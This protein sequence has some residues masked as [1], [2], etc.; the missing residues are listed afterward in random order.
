MHNHLS[1]E[2]LSSYCVTP[3]ATTSTVCADE[4]SGFPIVMGSPDPACPSPPPHGQQPVLPI[5]TTSLSVATSPSESSQSSPSSPSLPLPRSPVPPAT[6]CP[7]PRPSTPPLSERLSASVSM[8]ASPRHIRA[9]ILDMHIDFGQLHERVSRQVE[10]GLLSCGPFGP[11]NSAVASMGRRRAFSVSSAPTEDDV[12]TVYYDCIPHPDDLTSVCSDEQYHDASCDHTPAFALI[13]PTVLTIRPSQSSPMLRPVKPSLSPASLPST[14]VLETVK[15]PLITPAASSHSSTHSIDAC[16]EPSSPDHDVSGGTDTPRV[17]GAKVDNTLRELWLTEVNYIN[18]LDTFV[19]GYLKTIKHSK[20]LSCLLLKHLIKYLIPLVYFQKSFSRQLGVTI[21]HAEPRVAP[22]SDFDLLDLARLFISMYKEFE[23]YIPYCAMAG[24]FAADIKH[25]EKGPEWLQFSRHDSPDGSGPKLSRLGMLDY[26]MKP[27]Q[28]LC[29]YPLL[30]KSIAKHYST[31]SVVAQQITV[32]LD[33]IQTL[34]GRIN[35]AKRD[36]EI[37]HQTLLFRQRYEDTA[38]LPLSFIASMGDLVLAGALEVVA[39]DLNPPRIKYYGCVL[40]PRFLVLLKTKST[41]TYEPKHWFPLASLRIDDQTSHFDSLDSDNGLFTALPVPATLAS[42]RLFHEPTQRYLDFTA[43]CLE[44]KAV[45]LTHLR[46]CL[47]QVRPDATELVLSGS[48]SIAPAPVATNMVVDQYPSS[49]ELR[50]PNRRTSNR[51]SSLTQYHPR[52]LN[53]LRRIPSN[54]HNSPLAGQPSPIALTPVAIGG[55]GDPSPSRRTGE[56]PTETPLPLSGTPTTTVS[57]LNHRNTLVDSPRVQPV[58][59]PLSLVTDLVDWTEHHRPQLVTTFYHPGPSRKSL[60]DTRF[61]DIFTH[62]CLR[63]RAQAL[64]HA[65]ATPGASI[66]SLPITPASSAPTTPQSPSGLNPLWSG[67]ADSNGSTLIFPWGGSSTV[68]MVGAADQK[69]DEKS[70]PDEVRNRRAVSDCGSNARRKFSG[71]SFVITTTT[72]TSAPSPTT[73]GISGS[74]RSRS[75]FAPSQPTNYALARHSSDGRSKRDRFVLGGRRLAMTPAGTISP[76]AARTGDVLLEG[77]NGNNGGKSRPFSQSH[78]V[79][80]S[81]ASRSNKLLNLIGRLSINR[82]PGSAGVAHLPNPELYPQEL[83]SGS[84]AVPS[85][86]QWM[87]GRDGTSDGS[88]V[89]RHFGQSGV[90]GSAASS[91]TTLDSMAQ[92][93]MGLADSPTPF[94]PDRLVEPNGDRAS[95]DSTRTV[96]HLQDSSAPPHPLQI[97][98]SSPYYSP[99]HHSSATAAVGHPARGG[100]RPSFAQKMHSWK[101]FFAV[102]G[103]PHQSAFSSMTVAPQNQSPPGS[104]GN[105]TTPT[106]SP[107]TQLTDPSNDR[108]MA[109]LATAKPTTDTKDKHPSRSS[110]MSTKASTSQLTVVIK[111]LE[112]PESQMGPTFDVESVLPDSPLSHVSDLDLG[113]VPDSATSDF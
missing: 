32:A 14:S 101:S 30:L 27:I 19:S 54:L 81:P 64:A 62:D 61:G 72:A 20:Q 73:A 111:P 7:T 55:G 96:Y 97:H 46:E 12:S 79:P 43:S 75:W 86:P 56:A 58:P 3:L 42:W 94:S 65:G 8:P 28:R 35:E 41:T 112:I 91:T 34:I 109:T 48:P 13:P 80:H 100:V 38:K 85:S 16:D 23:V 70:S 22:Y 74:A 60:V 78:S 9:P 87:R 89:G 18:A 98:P 17:V 29:L 44:E 51:R 40:F 52:S 49:F 71:R 6:A 15:S 50:A 5:R 105:P 107:E 24:N 26:L 31:D 63:S 106:L 102:E 53:P 4:V 1:A 103:G 84:S 66:H 2:Q 57:P 59:R 11:A 95:S 47:A 83:T 39:Y 45:W 36:C 21:G 33:G 93:A 82:S 37:H 68:T 113:V 108:K 110:S 25:L 88:V 90:P 10:S 104:L 67:L 92:P 77:S 99:H 69:N 76:V